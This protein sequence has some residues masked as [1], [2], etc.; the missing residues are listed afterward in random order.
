LPDVFISYNREDRET[1][2]LVANALEAEGFSVW[3]DA[4]LRAGETYDEVTEANLRQAGAVVVLWSKRSANSKWV[5]AEATVGERSSTLVP[6]LIEECDRPVRFEL[7]QTADLT[8]W[9]GD[10]ND[11]N[12]QAFMQ[13]IETAISRRAAKGKPPVGKPGSSAPAQAAGA[14]PEAASIETTF[15]N[16]VKDGSERSDFEAYLERYPHGHFAALAKNRIAAIDRAR[17]ARPQT[18]PSAAS[19]PP[20]SAA[21][22]RPTAQPV[23]QRQAPAQQRAAAPP[24]QRQVE[25]AKG[26]A[27]IF[28][29]G[30]IAVTLLALAGG[31]MFALNRSPADNVQTP[32]TAA[33]AETE[34]A[35]PAA[36][37]APPSDPS[38]GVVLGPP[39]EMAASDDAAAPSPA[40]GEAAAA[41]DVFAE[42]I[43]TG[44]A[45]STDA[46]GFAEA[47]G[48]TITEAEPTT[49]APA[50]AVEPARHVATP[51]A[52]GKVKTFRDCDACP[53]MA[54]IEKGSFV[55]GSPAGEAGRNGYEGP[56][57]TVEIGEFAIGVYEVTQAEWTACAAAG[58]C[59]AKRSDEPLKPVL[60]VSW[61]EAKAY[62]DWLSTTTKRS[63]RLPSEAEWEYAARGGTTSAYWWGETIDRSKV[64]TG[65]A[66]PVGSLEANGYGLHDVLS[67]AREWVE[68]CYVNTYAGA[69][70][71][72][73][74]IKAGDCSRR[75]IRGG[76]WS[77]AAADMRVANRSRI[78]QSVRPLYMGVR[79]AA[80]AKK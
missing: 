71:D 4:A 74:A 47:D 66:K 78:D 52:P 75:V 67:N 19:R 65:A 15:W 9:K 48:E 46:P 64:A 68:D 73:S 1:A 51:A 76:A 33:E 16:S 57:R 62:A 32:A 69:P 50:P 23:Q 45:Q 12:W 38:A 58:A 25:E 11:P 35:P 17:P 34:A 6:A 53:L 55:M 20:Q 70:A 37:Q 40:E 56:Q 36:P 24:P 8:R 31:A 39:A 59:A 49:A 29:I 22:A 3:W 30:G 7:V 5:R 26:G 61:R 21:Q 80:E 28:L 43:T 18:G 77:S 79:I 72:G 63:Y 42:A 60:G 2:R 10:R 13:D 27:N 41:E 54:R 14:G 44:D